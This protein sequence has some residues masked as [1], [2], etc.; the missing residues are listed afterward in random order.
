MLPRSLLVERIKTNLDILDWSLSED[1]WNRINSIEPQLSLIGE[2]H[3]LSGS[4]SS[5]MPLPSVVET[6]DG[7]VDASGYESNDDIDEECEEAEEVEGDEHV[8]MVVEPVEVV[9]E[10]VE[11]IEPLDAAACGS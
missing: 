1:D 11:I 2:T 6:L 4:L 5:N 8:E 10:E 7:I 3:S 9:A